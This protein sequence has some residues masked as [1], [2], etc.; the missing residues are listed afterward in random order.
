MGN[1]LRT[2]D[3]PL[4]EQRRCSLP[5]PL[6]QNGL[7]WPSVRPASV[8]GAATRLDRNTKNA[9]FLC[10]PQIDSSSRRDGSCLLERL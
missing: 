8:T 3:P 9:L 1:S 7:S 10:A 6:V 2:V 4:T 5:A